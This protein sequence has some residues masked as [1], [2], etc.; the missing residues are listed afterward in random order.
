MK[1]SATVVLGACVLGTLMPN[2]S[3]AQVPTQVPTQRPTG[4]TP[5]QAAQLLRQNPQLGAVLRQRLQQSGLA[6]DQ[7]RAQ[8]AASGY[9]PNLLDAYLSP[10]QP[11]QPAP[12]PTVQ[13]LAA[14]QALGLAAGSLAP[15][16]LSVDTGFIRVRAESLRAESLATGS[17]VFGVDVFR[18]ATSQFLPTRAGPVPPDYRLGPRDQLALILAGD[19]ERSYTV[20]VSRDGVILVPQVGQIF[21]SSLTLDQ[22]R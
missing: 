3:H 4:M 2:R 6:P 7:I 1:L 19:I 17:Y 5:E 13:V 10:Q 11:G 14:I 20:P 12:L 9:P 22:L 18:R 15:E 21:V 16:S 8:L